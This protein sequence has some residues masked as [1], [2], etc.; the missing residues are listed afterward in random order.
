MISPEHFVVSLARSV[1]LFRTR[2]DAVE[3]QKSALRALVAMCKLQAVRLELDGDSIVAMGT[4]VPSSLPGV[5]S[6][7]VQ[8][9]EHQVTELRFSEEANPADVLHLLRAL[10]G[11]RGETPMPSGGTVSLV[12]ANPAPDPVVPKAAEED[13]IGAGEGIISSADLFFNTAERSDGDET[14]LE[15][16]LQKL[17]AAP[18][19][20]D[21]LSRVSRVAEL[22]P[23]KMQENRVEQAVMSLATLIE[24]EE[25]A[26]D[27]SATQ[28]YAIAIQ[29]VLTQENVAVFVPMLLDARCADAVSVIIKRADAVGVSV[30]LERIDT[31][32]EAR[33]C[34]AYLEALGAID[35]GVQPLLDLLGSPR[36]F[37]VESVIAQL[38]AREIADA[39]PG[40]I[41]HLGHSHPKVREAAAEA[42]ARIGNAQAM[43][44]L[45]HAFTSA[46]GNMTGIVARAVRG[47]KSASF[48]APLVA[49]VEKGRDTD[50]MRDC[51][52]ALGRIGTPEALR[53]LMSAAE[54]G[55]RLVGRKPVERRVAALE[56]LRLVNTGV[57]HRKLEQLSKDKNDVVKELALKIIEEMRSPTPSD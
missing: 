15:G 36:W 16:L 7:A 47:R 33:E 29:R 42:L 30:L 28:G 54:P 3:E 51:Y 43:E 9:R 57:V 39:V 50:E 21:V 17:R 4:S 32:P 27:G 38:G 25:N 10:A 44:G 53:A 56:G 23:A 20:G 19:E 45:R 8:L 13:T 48:V 14:S 34:Q 41:G 49:M 31:V 24:L 5:S 26:L 12:E 37:V 52:R 35:G 55:G 6:L 40:L 18:Y 1:E 22:I 46:D 2:P 11:R